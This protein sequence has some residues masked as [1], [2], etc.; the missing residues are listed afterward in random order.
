M[1]KDR[2]AALEFL[3]T[4]LVDMKAQLLHMRQLMGAMTRLHES[5]LGALS[6]RGIL[7]S[8]DPM[9]QQYRQ[10]L[11]EVKRAG[12]NL[13]GPPAAMESIR[14]PGCGA[15]LSF[16][17]GEKPASCQWCGQDL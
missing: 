10:V 3:G 2:S 4:E 13:A 12:L 11:E 16:M 5:V 15:K 7:S 14:C 9:V 6:Q 1:K 17:P 8:D